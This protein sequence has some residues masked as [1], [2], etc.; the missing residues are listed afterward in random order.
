MERFQAGARI[1]A[2]AELVCERHVT[3]STQGMPLSPNA[4]RCGS[5][6]PVTVA[7][8]SIGLAL[9][10]PMT[11]V[12]ARTATTSLE[13][14]DAR[15]T[16]DGRSDALSLTIPPVATETR[17][18]SQGVRAWRSPRE[19]QVGLARSDHKQLLL[20]ETSS[21]RDLGSGAASGSDLPHRHE[22]ESERTDPRAL[23]GASAWSLVTGTLPVGDS[24][25]Q[26]VARPN[27]HG[28]S[29][30]ARGTF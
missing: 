1:F 17:E 15:R 2:F 16:S 19:L 11:E 29:V 6:R 13:Q 14:P 4:L 21:V 23:L 22:T 10:V 30:R 9:L 25:L 26:I 18:S 27:G 28:G 7:L 5:N 3:C 8:C 12:E 20:E 24:G